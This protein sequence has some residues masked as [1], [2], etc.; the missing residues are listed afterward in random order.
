MQGGHDTQRGRRQ[1]GMQQVAR[2]TSKLL[3]LLLLLL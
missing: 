3:L 2:P 1:A